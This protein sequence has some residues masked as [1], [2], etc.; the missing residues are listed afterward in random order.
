MINLPEK[1]LTPKK[2]QGA[3]NQLNSPPYQ[4]W[5]GGGRP[6]QTMFLMPKHRACFEPRLVR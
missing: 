2:K 4:E 6:R 5:A 1:F 3:R